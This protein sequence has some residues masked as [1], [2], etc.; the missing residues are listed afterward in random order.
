MFPVLFE[1]P[2]GVPVRAYGV[3]VALGFLVAAY[4]LWPRLLAV[5]GND[6][7]RDPSRSAQVALWT[8]IG[9]LIGGRLGFVA[10]ELLRAWASPEGSVIGR[11]ILSAPWEALY[12]WKGGGVMYG[13]LAGALI[14]GIACARRV[15]LEL[16]TALDTGLVCGAVGLAIGRVGCLLVGDDHGRVVPAWAEDLPFPITL[17]IPDSAWL[18]EHPE[19][20]LPREAAG[21]LLWA[22]QTWMSLAALALAV[23]GLWLLPHRRRPGQVALTLGAVYAIV[24][25]VIECFRGDTVRGV[26]FD[27]AVST[28]QLVSLPLFIGCTWWLWRTRGEPR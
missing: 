18:A 25:S 15:G 13:G 20:L 1:L 27:G 8:L 10:V 9:L 2:G 3:L 5:H 19:S 17:R 14:A 11:Q 28:S 23:L 12:F 26:W 4:G 16:G 6:P 7:E 21:E 22:T 24:R